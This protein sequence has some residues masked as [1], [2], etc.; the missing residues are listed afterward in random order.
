MFSTVFSALMQGME[1]QIVQVETDISDGLPVFS[2]V[3]YLSASVR[4]AE[5]R[6]KT[7]IRNC[8]T[9]LPAK[10][11]T[12]NLSPGDV[13]KQ[14]AR[15]DLPIAVSIMAALGLAE[16]ESL[17]ETLFLGE[18][19]LDGSV[20][21]VSGILPT[22][23]FAK[24]MGF[25][26]CVVPMD[27]AKE[28][29]VVQGIEVIGVDSFRSVLEYLDCPE[30][31]EPA[32]ADLEG[33]FQNNSESE[34]DFSEIKG[35]RQ[36]RRGAEIAAAGMHNLLL[37]GP[38]GAGKTMLARRIPTIFPE[39][40][41][42]ESMEISKIYSVT[43]SLNGT[44]PLITRRPFRIPHHTLT[45]SALCGGGRNPMPGEVSLAHLGVLFLDE[46]TEYP[47]KVLECLRQPMEDGQIQ[48]TRVHGN[49]I[50]PCRFMTVAAMNP[51]PC[52]FYPDRE[53]CSCSPAEIR[54]HLEHISQPLLDR[55][56]ICVEVSSNPFEAL[57]QTEAG[58]S[59]EAIR[60]RIQ[61][62]IERQRD[63]FKGTHIHFNSRIPASCIQEYCPLHW[64]DEARMEHVFQKL[65]LSGR[66]YHKILK[67]ARSIADLEDC[68]RIQTRHLNE[69]VCYR[70]ID[71]KYWIR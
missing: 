13:R 16:K 20:R 47:K 37:L 43:G 53:R 49:Y 26:R 22:V 42:E 54:R 23:I 44:Q 11:I 35:Q 45:A 10:R 68:D 29:S 19:G 30:T 28:G 50:Y 36:M 25:R 48:I 52:G 3:G 32:R 64:A 40:T 2:M 24:D 46:L 8:G 15:F 7:A 51:C 4:E 62:A 55:L 33:L 59:S 66:G 6:V 65:R 41:L 21:P 31:F 9:V 18:L 61:M 60:K 5:D 38:A 12:V 57:R 27:N 58:E 71:K 56:D 1:P 69:A 63:R 34:V 70:S 67:V 14:G 39:L 17:S